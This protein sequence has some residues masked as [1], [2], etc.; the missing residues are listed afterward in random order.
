MAG[1]QVA[2]D[3]EERFNTGLSCPGNHGLSIV[4]V[5]GVVEVGVGIDQHE[6]IVARAIPMEKVLESRKCRLTLRHDYYQLVQLRR[7]VGM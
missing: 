5:A 7:F 3:G 4:V 1:G 2:T 6:R